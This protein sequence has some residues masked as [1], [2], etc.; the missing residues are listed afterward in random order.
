MEP[1][2]PTVAEAV[3]LF[4]EALERRNYAA[5]TKL[6]YRKNLDAFVRWLAAVGPD[7]ATTP[8]TALTRA[9]LE[10]FQDHLA[11][12][13]LA[14][15]TQAVRI[16]ALK[17]LF[18]L[19]VD[20]GVLF[21]SPARGLVETPEG[22]KRLPE[23]LTVDEVMRMLATPDTSTKL[24]IRDRAVLELLYDT[25]MRRG[26]LAALDVTDVDLG[27]RAVRIRSGKGRIGRVAPLG[28]SAA[29]GFDLTWRRCD[30]RSR[31]PV[32]RTAHLPE[33]DRCAARPELA[34][35][36]V[37]TAA[38]AAGITKRVYVHTL[39][40]TF[41]THLVQNGADIV[42]VQKLLGH[43]SP[44]TTSAVYTRVAPMELKRSHEAVHPRE[45]EES[46]SPRAWSCRFSVT[47]SVS[48]APRHGAPRARGDPSVRR[49]PRGR[50]VLTVEQPPGDRADFK[51]TWLTP[52]R[53]AVL[54]RRAQT[55]RG[56]LTRGEA[57]SALAGSGGL[58]GARP[59]AGRRAPEAGSP[60]AARR[61]R[62]T[63]DEAPARSARR[64][65]PARA[66]RPGNPR[67]LLLDRHS[68]QR[69]HGHPVG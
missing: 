57:L 62:R 23:V 60:A 20:R 58:L 66:A 49:S 42:T 37:R 61:D 47:A 26:E 54:A 59:G 18:E 15:H 21:L 4:G 29:L 35:R 51:T 13:V 1:K 56:I 46:R 63:R 67:G 41:A 53:S 45:Q 69:A 30:P 3:A 10:R 22:T 34:R 33:R 64:H 27:D 38:R 9:D 55:R 52:R 28:G 65:E 40:H 14:K 36:A 68:R 24:G 48:G 7:P 11:A 31:S 19:L 50:G 8:V 32:V 25:G 44:A 43:A 5:A 12:S 2:P 39:R 16:R 6:N 17:R